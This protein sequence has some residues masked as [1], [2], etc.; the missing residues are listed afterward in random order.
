VLPVAIL[1]IGWPVESPPAP[2]ARDLD[3]VVSWIE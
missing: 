3:E 1:S 2:P